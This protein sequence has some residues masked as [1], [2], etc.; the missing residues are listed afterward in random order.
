MRS[1]ICS[2]RTSSSRSFPVITSRM[3]QVISPSRGRCRIGHV[4]AVVAERRPRQRDGAVSRE[5][6]WIDQHAGR[7]LSAGATYTTP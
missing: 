1:R 5:A 6:V 3:R 4:A 2:H 7:P